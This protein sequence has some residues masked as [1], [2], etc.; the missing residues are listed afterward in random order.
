MKSKRA[1]QPSA[2]GRCE[3]LEDRFVLNA[4]VPVH[5]AGVNARAELAVQAAFQ[6]PNLA[7]FGGATTI[8]GSQS[9]ALRG[10][11]GSLK[12]HAGVSL[13]P[14][15]GA[16]SHPSNG[17]VGAHATVPNTKFGGEFTF[18]GFITE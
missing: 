2:F 16:V 7:P 12:A 11:F 17:V 18:G 4:H 13:S 3:S 5:H 14:S 6:I 10:S 8:N 9:S 15:T 1:F